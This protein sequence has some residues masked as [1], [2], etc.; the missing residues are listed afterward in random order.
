MLDYIIE[1]G[2]KWLVWTRLKLKLIKLECS[3]CPP[4]CACQPFLMPVAS[5][6]PSDVGLT[7]RRHNIFIY[8]LPLSKP[9]SLSL[10]HIHT[11]IWRPVYHAIVGTL[12][13]HWPV[14]THTSAWACVSSYW[15][16]GQRTAITHLSLL[17]NERF[18]KLCSAQH[19]I[20]I[21]WPEWNCSKIQHLG[22]WFPIYILS[23][24]VL[25][26]MDIFGFLGHSQYAR[27]L[28]SS[29]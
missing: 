8:S 28:S 23:E 19:R 18:R 4:V 12:R 24:C 26:S 9:L 22:S 5:P 7:I 1:K 29:Y 16:C 25:L 2:H 27:V 21:K 17:D 6:C 15:V 20:F 10:W 14:R 13:I 11:F 3:K